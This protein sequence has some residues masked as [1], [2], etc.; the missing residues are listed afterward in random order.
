MI[1]KYKVFIEEQVVETI[2]STKGSNRKNIKQ[3]VRSLS[4]DPFQEGDFSETD[5]IGRETFCKLIKDYAVSF[6]SD[7]A[8]KEIK[9]FQVSRADK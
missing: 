4:E 9:I 3:F 8:A 1:E 6:Y 5:R 2:Q 7:H